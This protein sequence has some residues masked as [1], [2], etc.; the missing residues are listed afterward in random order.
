[1]RKKKITVFA[2]INATISLLMLN[3]TLGS[4]FRANKWSGRYVV[5]LYSFVLCFVNYSYYH[6]FSAD[7]DTTLIQYSFIPGLSTRF[8]FFKLLKILLIMI[9]PLSLYFWFGKK[10]LA[11]FTKNPIKRTGCFCW[12]WGIIDE[13]ASKEH[14]NTCNYD[15]EEDVVCPHEVDKYDHTLVIRWYKC[16]EIFPYVCGCKS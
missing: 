4:V 6:F 1:M 5:I 10:L 14:V 2:M 12:E 15:S 7:N 8:V 11:L 3:K 9:I 13:E 16:Y